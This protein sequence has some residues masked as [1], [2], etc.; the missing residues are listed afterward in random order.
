MSAVGASMIQMSAA[1]FFDSNT[2]LYL[3]SGD[4]AKAERIETILGDGGIISIQVLNEFA[5]VA[6]RK[7]KMPIPFIRDV[8][9]KI[10]AAC[11]LQP[12]DISTHE[13]GLD[14]AER[15]KYSIY[16]SMLIA[17]ALQAGCTTF[18]T[19]DLHDGH[20]IDGL[21]IQNPFRT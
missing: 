4:A 10:R 19:E 3:M 8:L 16:D 1:K 18:Y 14:I 21:T 5:S 13:R 7:F 15:Y 12:T 17:A 9:S 6:S 11:S 2:L 20:R